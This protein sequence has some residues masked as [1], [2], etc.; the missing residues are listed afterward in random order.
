MKQRLELLKSNG[1]VVKVSSQVSGYPRIVEILRQKRPDLFGMADSSSGQ[2]NLSASGFEQR[3]ASNSDGSVS[4]SAFAGAKTFR[5]SFLRQYGINVVLIFFCLL[6]VWL[7]FQEPENQVAAFVAAGFCLLMMVFTLF[8]VSAVKV[9]PNRL[10]IETLFEQ[11][12]LSARQIKDIKMQSVRGRHGRVTNFVVIIPAEG[13]K[14]SL[15]GFAEGEEILY[16][17]LTNWWNA[18]RNR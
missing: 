14:Y 9:E 1:Q 18:Y 17:F 2:G 12:E 8:Q 3:P 10:T 13:K 4:A 6:F 7:A 11:K 16:G 15:G 5:K